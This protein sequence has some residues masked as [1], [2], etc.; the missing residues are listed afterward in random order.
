MPLQKR[1]QNPK[2]KNWIQLT[3]DFVKEWPD[4]LEGLSFQSMPIKYVKWV[5]IILKNKA[6]LKL[7]IEQELKIKK[8]KAIADFLKKYLEVNYKHIATVDLKF[9]VA[10]LRADMESKTAK[11]LDRTF[12][13]N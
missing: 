13:K 12:K 11:I 5:H 8:Q 1:P 6:T 9:D 2:S 4:V 7:D 10:R 3:R